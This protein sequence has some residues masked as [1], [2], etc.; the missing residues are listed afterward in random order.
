MK[1]E[2]GVKRKGLKRNTFD[3]KRGN[4]K[5]QWAEMKDLR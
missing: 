3:E 5:T 4:P 1:K 2:A